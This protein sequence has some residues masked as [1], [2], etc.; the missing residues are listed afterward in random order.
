MKSLARWS[1]RHRWIML[2]AWIVLFLVINIASFTA[3]SFYSNTFSLPGTNSTHAL[4]LLESGF[5]SK[6]GDVD[7]IAFPR[8]LS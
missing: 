6:S 2:G 7:D 5:K 8:A 4:K 1:V 3:G